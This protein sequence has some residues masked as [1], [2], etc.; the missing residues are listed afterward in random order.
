MSYSVTDMTNKP[1]KNKIPF[2]FEQPLNRF[3]V[4]GGKYRAS[5]ES[6][7]SCDHK[8]RNK[9]IQF[10]FELIANEDGPVY[11]RV[12]K[13]FSDDKASRAQ[14]QKFIKA[15]FSEDQIEALTKDGTQVDLLELQGDRVDLLIT[16]KNVTGC[17]EP[18]PE[19]DSIYS[20]GTLLPEFCN[21]EPAD[22]YR[23]KLAW[24]LAMTPE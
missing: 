12:G 24:I 4:P 5:L 23:E 14:M 6:V 20:P 13:L 22:V 15:F 17:K 8:D 11:Y 18:L 16:T 21:V 7:T 10:M 1:L 2:T 3:A 9:S 19:I